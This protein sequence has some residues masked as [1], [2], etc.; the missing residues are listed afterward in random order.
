MQ[1]AR[2]PQ[3]GTGGEG[4][5]EERSAREHLKLFIFS[6]G[7]EFSEMLRSFFKKICF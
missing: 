3:Q 7:F 4:G 6:C 2:H 5:E 1:P